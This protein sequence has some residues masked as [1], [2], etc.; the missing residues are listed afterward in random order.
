MFNSVVHVV[1]I[2]LEKSANASVSCSG[3]AVAHVILMSCFYLTFVV[4]VTAH[5]EF[6]GA[7]TG[8]RMLAGEESE[9]ITFR[10]RDRSAA[11]YTATFGTKNLLNVPKHKYSITETTR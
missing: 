7:W 11:H 3:C 9:I 6:R 2:L 5:D 8:G 4:G 1:T 10:T